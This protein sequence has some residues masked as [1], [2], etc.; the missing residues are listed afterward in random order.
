MKSLEH[1]YD[2]EVVIVNDGSKDDTS[3]LA[4][5]FAATNNNVH[6]F[7]HVVNFGL[8]QALKFAFN[9]CHGQYIV[10]LDMDLSY[11]PDHI[12]RLVDRLVATKAK[13]VIAS[14]YLR[15]G[16]VKNV[17]ALRKWL[18][19]GANKFLSI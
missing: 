7:D 12:E 19:V 4:K 15:G 16:D 13:V 18:S 1:K 2:W 14:P 9:Q 17:P 5:Q 3:A 11:S 8:G 10:T 6:V